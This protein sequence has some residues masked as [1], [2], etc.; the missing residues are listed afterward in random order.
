M[1]VVLIAMASSACGGSDRWPEAPSG[2]PLIDG[3]FKN[4]VYANGYG[5]AYTLEQLEANERALGACEGVP[6]E[7]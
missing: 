5:E 1:V 2:G 6:F 4:C 7:D 3:P